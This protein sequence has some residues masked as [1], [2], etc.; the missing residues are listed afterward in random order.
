MHPKEDII[1]TLAHG[2]S[3]KEIQRHLKDNF[4]AQKDCEYFD[5]VVEFSVSQF[6]VYILRLYVICQLR[7]GGGNFK[8]TTLHMVVIQSIT[9]GVCFLR[10]CLSEEAYARL[11]RYIAALSF[12]V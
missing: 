10:D 8:S 7:S 11:S 3:A 1:I 4:A 12:G 9:D 5:L 6:D 2:V